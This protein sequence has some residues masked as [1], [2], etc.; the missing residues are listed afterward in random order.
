[1]N[2]K[3]LLKIVAEYI[4]RHPAPAEISLLDGMLKLGYSY[5]MPMTN[6]KNKM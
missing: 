2:K 1:M 4:K 5:T 3:S 6:S